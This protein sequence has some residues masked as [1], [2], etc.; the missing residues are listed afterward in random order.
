MCLALLV[1]AMFRRDKDLSSKLLPSVALLGFLR[2]MWSQKDNLYVAQAASLDDGWPSILYAN[3]IM[4][5]L[6]NRSF[7]HAKI[8]FICFVFN[9]VLLVC[10]LIPTLI[11][12]IL[13]LPLTRIWFPRILTVISCFG[14]FY[15]RFTVADPKFTGVSTARSYLNIYFQF[16]TIASLLAGVGHVWTMCLLTA[17]LMISM[18]LLRLVV[19]NL[20]S[21]I[22]NCRKLLQIGFSIHCAILGRLA[23]I[24]SGQRL[25]FGALHV[26]INIAVSH[27]CLI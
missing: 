26:S 18:W 21:D 15:G 24:C 5:V 7:S 3:L 25:D 27:K 8:P 2:L 14:S 23:F 1:F 9:Q 17:Y 22:V 19:Y 6:Y 12:P 10:Y 13:D 11:E 16:S 4:I 20:S